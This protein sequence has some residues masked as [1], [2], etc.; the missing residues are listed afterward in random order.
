MRQGHSSGDSDFDE[1]IVEMTKIGDQIQSN[2]VV[3]AAVNYLQLGGVSIYTVNAIYTEYYERSYPWNHFVGLALMVSGYCGWI[4]ARVALGNLFAVRPKALG[5]VKTGIY[6]K[7]RN[8]IYVFGTIYF[9]GLGIYVSLSW[10]LLALGLVAVVFA[11]LFRSA[12]EAKVLQEHYGEE[13]DQ[14]AKNAWV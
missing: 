4:A 11:Q 9:L 8:P 5:L 13:Y 3:K 10:W 6:S 2:P 14:Y 12:A 1:L 7:I